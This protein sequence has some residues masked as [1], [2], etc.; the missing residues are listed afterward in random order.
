M[1]KIFLGLMAILAFAAYAQDSTITIKVSDLEKVAPGATVALKAAMEVQNVE[2]LVD[3]R[4][5]R[6]GKWV[7]LGNEIG[8]AINGCLKALNGELITLSESKIG[9]VAVFLVIWKV[10]F[11]D[12]IGLIVGIPIFIVW[13]ILGVWV[14]KRCFIA[15]I[16]TFINQGEKT[17]MLV[18]DDWDSDKWIALVVSGIIYIIVAA[19]LLGSVIL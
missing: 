5:K 10:L 19:I 6:Y 4:I 11:D 2:Q 17:E 16:V 7:G 14:V 3:E 9:K 15:R 1:I 18:N 12:V 8:I 13:T